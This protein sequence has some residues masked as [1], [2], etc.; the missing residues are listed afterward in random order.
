MNTSEQILV[1]ILSVALAVLL[2]LSI[3]VVAL[4]V[5]L[6]KSIQRITDKAENIIANVEHV[7]DTF[8]NVAGP[9]AVFRVINNIAKVVSKHG[10]KHR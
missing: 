1:I 6:V 8:K 10:G 3:V 7:G 9:M 5:K 4:I 2:V